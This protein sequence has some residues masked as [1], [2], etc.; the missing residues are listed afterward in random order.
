VRFLVADVLN[1]PQAAGQRDGAM[2]LVREDD[3]GGTGVGV[4]VEDRLAQG[5]GATVGKVQDGERARG[6]PVF[7]R[8]QP[9]QDA[10]SPGVFP[11]MASP[12]RTSERPC[13]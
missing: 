10:N 13:H 8:L 9:A 3:C 11:G 5:A 1:P 4:G 7:Q 6:E 12:P 2:Q